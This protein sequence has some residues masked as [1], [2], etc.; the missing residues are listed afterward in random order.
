M[1]TT[2]QLIAR[3]A[4]RD[5]LSDDELR[6]LITSSDE[7]TASELFSQA[8]RVRDE[9]Y[10]PMV[11]LRGL[12]EISNICPNDC[13]YC[14]IRRSNK[15]AVRYRLTAA[16]ILTA[17]QR[18]YGLG[19]RTFVLQGGEDPY[20]TDEVLID[21]I[22]EIKH[23]FPDCAVTL[24]LGERSPESYRQLKSAGADRYLLRHETADAHHYGLLH[25]PAMS[26]DRRMSCLKEL[27]AVGYQVGCGFMVG[28]PGQT[29]N[30]LVRELR[31]LQS[32]RPHMVGIG[33][34]LPHH[35]T[36]FAQEKPGDVDLTL[37]LLALIRLLLPDVL[38]P[39][40]TALGTAAEDGQL[41][42]L[43]A[44]ANV[45]MPNLTPVGARENYLLYDNKKSVGSEGADGIGM[46]TKNLVLHGYHVAD[47]RGDSARYVSADDKL[48][49]ANL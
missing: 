37:R 4:N 33:P 12:V 29:V 11:F 32:F 10:G 8:R 25:P 39:A 9:I 47:G 24:S 40:T 46:L 45:I 6:S 2:H 30:H 44:G 3:L 26:F 19:L 43:E 13:L 1:R 20:F 16:E 38:L 28:S 41:Q 5:D 7:D 31:F 22:G 17:C 36:P 35:D 49:V 18:G 48:R 14:G 42:G 23:C 34:F 21:L 15:E 27:R